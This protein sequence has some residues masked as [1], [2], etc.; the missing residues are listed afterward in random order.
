MYPVRDCDREAQLLLG[1]SLLLKPSLQK[2]A[3]PEEGSHDKH[4]NT[5]SGQESGQESEP[6]GG[7]VKLFGENFSA[8]S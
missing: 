3:A 7:V 2:T 4:S 8:E 5:Q 1:K 6:V